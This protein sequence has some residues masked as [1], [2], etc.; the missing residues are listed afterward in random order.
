M[1]KSHMSALLI[2]L[3]YNLIF[4]DVFFPSEEEETLNSSSL[5]AFCV[6][7]FP[8]LWSLSALPTVAPQA[9]S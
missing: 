2:V 1:I 3:K 5:M 8:L 7:L 6:I 9:W 4:W